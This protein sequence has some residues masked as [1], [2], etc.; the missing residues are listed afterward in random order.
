MT[1]VVSTADWLARWTPRLDAFLNA[2]F[3]A[4][5]FKRAMRRA[6]LASVA[7]RDET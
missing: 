2:L 3:L 7:K 5:L 1:A 4:W 6:W